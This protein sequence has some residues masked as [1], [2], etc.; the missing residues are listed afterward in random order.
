MR[1]SS[2]NE[3]VAVKPNVAVYPFWV[4]CA[5][6]RIAEHDLADLR[7]AFDR[8]RQT[9]FRASEQL[10]ESLLARDAVRRRTS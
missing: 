3:T 7:A 2:M 10:F 8:L 9:N 4:R 5:C 6:L 1:C